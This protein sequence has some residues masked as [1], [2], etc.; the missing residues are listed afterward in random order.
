MSD[1]VNAPGP[2]QQPPT[3][4]GKPVYVGKIAPYAGRARVGQMHATPA[5]RAI[6]KEQSLAGKAKR[7]YKSK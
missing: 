2:H 3:K 4:V 1:N 5:A 6:R 7:Y